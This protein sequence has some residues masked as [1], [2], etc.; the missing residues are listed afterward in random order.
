MSLKSPSSSTTSS[1]PP[2]SQAA[3]NSAEDTLRSTA[4]SSLLTIVNFSQKYA[5]SLQTKSF[6][7]MWSKIHPTTAPHQLRWEQVLDP[8]PNCV[9]DALLHAKSDTL[10]ALAKPYFDS[11]ENA[12]HICHLLLGSLSSARALYAGLHAFLP[13]HSDSPSHSSFT[14]SECNS[15]FDLFQEFDLPGNPFASHHSHSFDGMRHCFSQL[16]KHLHK[17]RSRVRSWGCC[18]KE[19]ARMA[20]LD[21]ALS[22]TIV[23][24]EELN[25]LDCLVRRLCGAVDNDKSLFRMALE[26][27]SEKHFIINIILTDVVKDLRKNHQSF[28]ELEE[29]ICICFKSINKARALL[30]QEIRL[31]H[32]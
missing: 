17:S 24:N 20:Q 13:L 16:K 31:H 15:A 23:L 8:D 14:Q 11:T 5:H 25:N 30:L 10:T 19:A 4:E 27:E 9:E 28:Q 1:A 26:R 18:C 6:E 32:T 12:A 2:H 22:S 29:R 21:D 7:D 3:G